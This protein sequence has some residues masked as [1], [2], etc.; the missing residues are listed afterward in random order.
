V[1]QLGAA[2]AERLGLVQEVHPHDE[3]TATGKTFPAGQA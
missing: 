1:P 2:E 3:L